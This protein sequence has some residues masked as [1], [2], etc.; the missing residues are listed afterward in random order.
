[1]TVKVYLGLGALATDCLASKRRDRP[2]CGGPVEKGW[3]K[4]KSRQ[5]HALDRV[6]Q[7]FATMLEQMQD[8]A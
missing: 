2:H 8:H 5:H 4:I 3:I 7:S 1:L 6:K